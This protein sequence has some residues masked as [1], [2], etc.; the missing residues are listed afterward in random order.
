[1]DS[2]L[3]TRDGYRTKA[4][5]SSYLNPEMDHLFDEGRHTLDMV[6][7]KR[8][9]Q[10][11][12]DIIERDKPIIPISYSMGWVLVHRRLHGVVFNPLGQSFAF[13]PGRRG[14][15]LEH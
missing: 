12:S 2:P 11:I 1:V 15:V 6:A 5:V 14:W 9:Y 8:I 10:Q 7:R 13:W 3:F 4:N